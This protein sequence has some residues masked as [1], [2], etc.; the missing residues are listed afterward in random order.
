MRSFFLP[1]WSP[2][3]DPARPLPAE[4]RPWPSDD[5]DDDALDDVS[6]MMFY[7]MN[8]EMEKAE[9]ENRLIISWK[10]HPIRKDWTQRWDK[11]FFL[12]RGSKS[13]LRRNAAGKRLCDPNK[14]IIWIFKSSV[15][16]SRHDFQ[17]ITQ[18]FQSNPFNYHLIENITKLIWLYEL[19]KLLWM[20]IPKHISYSSLGKL[21][22]TLYWNQ[23]KIL[24]RSLWYWSLDF[25]VD[26][27][28]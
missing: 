6:L 1:N 21:I 20:W 3:D 14:V 26:H 8:M 12:F 10:I 27:L 4:G 7:R 2:P 22:N 18:M 24:H 23:R 5:D 11:L 9:K 16:T 17:N 13:S 28:P 19:S 25:Y 15:C